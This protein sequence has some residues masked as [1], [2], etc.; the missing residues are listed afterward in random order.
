V[1]VM[2]A[3]E[4]CETGSVDDIFHDAQHPYA[5]GLVGSIPRLD[6][7]GGSGSRPFGGSR[8]TCSTCRRAARS[9]NAAI[10]CST[11]ASRSGRACFRSQRRA[12]SRAISKA[13]DR[14]AR[15]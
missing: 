7:P 12:R 9:R 15:C 1:N 11:V 3:G 5:R 2:Y 4:F 14:T 8:L 6:K 13:L 10:T